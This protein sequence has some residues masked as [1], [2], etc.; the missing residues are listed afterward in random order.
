MRLVPLATFAGKPRKISKG[1]ESAEPPPARVL[2][3]P[4]KKPTRITAGY[5]YHS[6]V[7]TFYQDIA[8]QANLKCIIGYNKIT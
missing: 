4:A 8:D 6:I 3:N 1:R 2:I 7:N 5:M